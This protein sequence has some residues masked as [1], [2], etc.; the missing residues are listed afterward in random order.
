MAV[1]NARLA[2]SRLPSGNMF[3]FWKNAIAA[4]AVLFAE[5][6]VDVRATDSRVHEMPKAR[7]FCTRENVVTCA[8]P[9]S[10]DDHRYALTNAASRT[11]RR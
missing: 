7:Y 3:T 4:E 1:P 2:A 10:W 6:E 11:L 8:R 5:K 9:T